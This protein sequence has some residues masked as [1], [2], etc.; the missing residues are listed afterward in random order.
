MLLILSQSVRFSIRAAVWG[1]LGCLSALLLMQIASA[2]GLGVLLRSAPGVFDVLRWGGALYLAYLGYRIF[3][4]PVTAPE[5]IDLPLATPGAPAP[6]VLYKTGFVTAA[7][8]PKALLFSAAFFPQFLDPALPQLP[9]FGILLG[10]FVVIETS[11]Y[12]V[13]AL[14][15]RKLAVHLKQV[16]VLKIFNRI[17][18]AAFV[19]FAA[20]MAGMK[21]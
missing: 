7:S 3:R 18:G 4:A 14:G 5:N 16:S 11:W 8:N 17:T 13:Y 10:S 2:A 1:A 9:Q 6:W 21:A 15:G 19:G 12:M 20:L